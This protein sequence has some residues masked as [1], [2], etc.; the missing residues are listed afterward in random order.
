MS[1][2]FRKREG[3]RWLFQDN[4]YRVIRRA[5]STGSFLQSCERKSLRFG[6]GGL[7]SSRLPGSYGRNRE[8]SQR[9]KMDTAISGPIYTPSSSESGLF[10]SL[11]N[12]YAAIRACPEK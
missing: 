2:D 8:S 12:I 11:A 5:T 9:G 4:L 7:K 10:E 6:L 1:K 3:G